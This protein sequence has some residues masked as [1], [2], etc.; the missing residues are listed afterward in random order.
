M[1]V[2]VPLRLAR[3]SVI[4]FGLSHVVQVVLPIV[5][6]RQRVLAAADVVMV[7]ASNSASAVSLSVLFVEQAGEQF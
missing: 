1:Y 7:R 5:V 6:E 3:H 2:V 4:P